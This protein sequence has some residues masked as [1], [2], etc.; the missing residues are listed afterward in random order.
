MK[1]KYPDDLKP[2]NGKELSD[3]EI[4]ELVQETTGASKE[5]E[6]DEYSSFLASIRTGNIKVEVEEFGH[7]IVWKQIASVWAREA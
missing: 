6:P 1:V 7:I 5:A 4:S 3:D 2:F